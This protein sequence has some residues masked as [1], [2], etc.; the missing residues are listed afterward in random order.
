MLFRS[1]PERHLTG[2]DLC[3]AV[4]QFSIQEYGYMARVVLK[5]WGLESTGDIGNIVYN[6]I[7]IGRMKKSE[8]DRRDH[9]DNVFDFENA[10]EKEFEI[11]A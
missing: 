1:S 2:Q 6:L 8:N 10:F 4:R 9:F 5:S 11:T 3:E 7:D